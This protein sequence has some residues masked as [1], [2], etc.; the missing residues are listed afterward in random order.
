MVRRDSPARPRAPPA[1]TACRRP[2]GRNGAAAARHRSPAAA[3]PRRESVGHPGRTGG[4]ESHRLVVPHGTGKTLGLPRRRLPGG[5]EPSHCPFRVDEQR[6]GRA[7]DHRAVGCDTVRPTVRQ[8]LAGER[9]G[10]PRPA[11]EH[12]PDTLRRAGKPS[13]SDSHTAMGCR[14]Q[15]DDHQ[16]VVG[17]AGSD[18]ASD[19]ASLVSPPW[20]APPI[21]LPRGCRSST[22]LGAA[23]RGGAWSWWACRHPFS[24][25]RQ[26][27]GK[28]LARSASRPA[29]VVDGRGGTPPN[30]SARPRRR[31]EPG[32]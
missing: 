1:G 3:T 27:R 22:N 21:A 25:S 13:T 19:S 26:R 7:M 2:A 8:P 18:I 15:V 6:A 5:N 16:V 32:T 17:S 24:L 20:R 28:A 31:R 9:G 11:T 23:G 30:P 14:R 12:E 10:L 29:L 4:E